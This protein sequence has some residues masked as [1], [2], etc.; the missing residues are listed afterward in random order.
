ME[1]SLSE[2]CQLVGGELVGDGA[3]R[4]HGISSAENVQEGCLIFAED[5]AHLKQA[6]TAQ[7]S[8]VLVSDGMMDLQGSP[9]IRSANPK[10]IWAQSLALFYPE[11]KPTL[12][13]H[14]TAIIG[15][16]VQLG[17]DICVEA[18][19]RLEAGV[20]VGRGSRIGAG[21]YVGHET[22]L[23]E[24]CVLYPNVTVYRRTKIDD[25][26]SIH[27]GSVIGGDGFGYTFHEG[28]YHKIPQTGDVRIESDVEIGCN[29][30][31]G[32]ATVGSTFIRKGTKI[33]NQVQI[34]HNNDIGQHVAIAGQSGLAGSVTVGNYTRLGGKVCVTDHVS[35]GQ[36]VNA[37]I[38]TLIIKSVDP[39][40]IIWGVPARPAWQAKRQ[41][42]S[43][44]KLPKF[45]NR[46]LSAED[47]M[48][49]Q[50]KRIQKLEQRIETLS[51]K[52]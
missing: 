20:S 51:S 5:A 24:D 8:A 30:C 46:W 28:T 38:G 36:G 43:L 49:Q 32:R 47:R 44:L 17:K 33:D 9:G 22:T 39:G 41:L 15:D 11:P 42:V 26:V 18:Y 37:G 21:A 13:V 3:T 45:L 4:I 29:V 40:E 1:L 52:T 19:V 25:R 14:P 50:E 31:V 34:A 27:S 48:Q 12:G 23:G 10:H 7:A 16:N 6:L 35:I 2:L